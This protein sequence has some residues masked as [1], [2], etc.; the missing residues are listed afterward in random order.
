MSDTPTDRDV[1]LAALH[2]GEVSVTFT[3]LDGTERT[4]RCTLREARLPV[5]VVDD[6][7][8]P[9]K[10]NEATVAVWDIDAGGW[11]SFLWDR[12]TS[13][14]VPTDTLPQSTEPPSV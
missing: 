11:R 7:K 14:G 1:L 3:K 2:Q 5:V 6:T 10:T 9:R 12:V 13:F 8:T 4:M